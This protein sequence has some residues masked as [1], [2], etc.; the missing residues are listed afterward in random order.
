[1]ANDLFNRYIWLI[2]TIH[3]AGSISFEEINR[4]WLKSSYSQGER[5]P[6]RTFHNW[7]EGIEEAFD[8]NICCQ[9]KGGYTYYIEHPEEVEQP[10]IRSMLLNTF[11]VNNLLNESQHLKKRIVL[12]QIPS[13][14]EFLFSFIEAMRDSVKVVI[15]HQSYR[16]SAPSCYTLHPYCL[17][18][19]HQRWYVVARCEERE[20]LLTFA[21]DRIQHIDVTQQPFRYPKQFD[22][23]QHFAHSFGIIT[24]KD[25]PVKRIRIK[26][27]GMLC[28]YLRSLPLHPS[29][30]EV[31]CTPTYAVFQYQLR[32]TYDFRQEL[33]SHGMDLEVLSPPGLRQEMKEQALGMIARYS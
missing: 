15:T 26:A 20:A 11:S 8:I 14:K 3:R 21:L 30:E 33:L 29:Q 10:G 19:F 25:H 22:P 27:Y 18:L 28:N 5:L 23:E 16:K 1:M 4:R 9:R 13:G 32:P 17:K 24:G 6:L 7:R 31:E 2:D 12:E